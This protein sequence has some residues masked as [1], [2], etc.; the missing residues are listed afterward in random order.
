MRG[1]GSRI[2]RAVKKE[3]QSLRG[4]GTFFWKYCTGSFTSSES[5]TEFLDWLQMPSSYPPVPTSGTGFSLIQKAASPAAKLQYSLR[6]AVFEILE[7][8]EWMFSNKIWNTMH[9]FF[10]AASVDSP[11][12]DPPLTSASTGQVWAAWLLLEGGAQWPWLLPACSL[13]ESPRWPV[14]VLGQSNSFAEWIIFS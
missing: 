13:S 12:N 9:F 3:Y 14:C 7:K 11:E 1:A 8:S 2:A 5:E 10:F 6:A 4:L